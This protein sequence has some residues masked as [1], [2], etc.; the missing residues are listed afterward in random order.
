MEAISMGPLIASNST[1][2]SVSASASTTSM[3]VTAPFREV[4]EAA[5]RAYEV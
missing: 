2:T 5:H 4:G 1:S 3:S